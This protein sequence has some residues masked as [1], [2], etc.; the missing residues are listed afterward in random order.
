MKLLLRSALVTLAGVTLGGLALSPRATASDDADELMQRADSIARSVAKLRGLKRK[1]PIQ[2]GVMNKDEIRQRLVERVDQEY[3]PEEL[4]AEEMALKRLAL[5]PRDAN[6]KQL[7]IDIFTEQI[8]GFYDPKDKKLYIAQDQTGESSFN[9]LLMAHEIDHALQ[10]QHFALHNFMKPNK[11]DSDATVARQA[12]VEGDGTALMFEF[13]MK[14]MGMDMPWAD[15]RT[16][17][18]MIAKMSAS[19]NGAPGTNHIPLV[20]REGMIFPYMAGLG[21]V[22]YFRR[23]HSWQRINRMYRKPPL[24]TEHILHPRKYEK[25]ERPDT[26]T[27][28]PIP[29]LADHQVVYDNVNG[30]FGLSL[31]LREHAGGPAGSRGKKTYAPKD[32]AERATAGWGGDRIAV[33][34]PPE[35]DGGV[36]GTIAVMYTVWDTE[37][38][39]IEFF[40]MLADSMPSL[41]NGGT[42]V[43]LTDKR[44]EYRS[45]EGE[46]FLAVRTGDAV[47]T[48]LGAP[49]D[50]GQTIADETAA[51]WQVRRR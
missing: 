22:S 31:I 15:T 7:V 5:L 3:T 34:T 13:M 51:K 40:E 6:Y 1:Q 44:A 50:R 37:A 49:A 39:A 36:A 11:R 4:S 42:E 16:T 41:A 45:P 10:D 24:S 26:I 28:N 30:E 32:K 33:Y 25:Y 43:A 17:D 2:R 20:L 9:D 21:F 12:L 47:V 46:S 18:A 38:D 19:M 35:H 14:R 8:A 29:T 27:I 23:Y 48:V